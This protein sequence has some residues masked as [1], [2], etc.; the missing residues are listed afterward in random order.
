MIK[1]RTL[2]AALI[3]MA[4]LVPF[5][6]TFAIFLIR[7]LV[8]GAAVVAMVDYGAVVLSFSGAVHWGFAL[9][10]NQPDDQQRDGCQLVFGVMPAL[11]GFLALLCTTQLGA[12]RVALGMLAAGYFATIVGETVGRGRQLVPTDYLVIRWAMTI[13]TLGVLVSTLFIALVGMRSG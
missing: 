12:P 6:A 5:I 3:S 2:A 11:I 8:S 4:G 9:R 10:A 1:N 7:P 13:V